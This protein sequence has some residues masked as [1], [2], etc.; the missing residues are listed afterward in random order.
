MRPLAVAALL[1]LAACATQKS[2][3]KTEP[4]VEKQKISNITYFDL[5]SCAAPA[6]ALPE[7]INKEEVFGAA[8]FARPAVLECFV[9]PKNRGPA[10]ESTASV[11]ITVDDSGAH[12]EVGGTNLT[13][14]GTKCIEGAMAKLP[15]KP[16]EKGAAAVST[17]VPFVHGGIAPAVKLGINSGSNVA[18][19]LRLAEAQWCDCWAQVKPPPPSLTVTV[20]LAPGKPGEFTFGP[21][22]GD[23]AALAQCLTQKLQALKLDAAGTELTLTYPVLLIDTLAEGESPD[24]RPELQFIQLD[25]I[26][27]ARAAE[28]ALK[29]GARG[30]AVSTYDALV[31]KYNKVKSSKAAAKEIPGLVKELKDR[32]AAMVKAD[33]AWI[34]ALTAQLTLEKHTEQVA[35]GL[36]AK[37]PMWADAEAAAQKTAE[38]TQAEVTKADGVKKADVGVCPKE[39]Y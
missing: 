21:A 19:Q 16:L 14:D 38:A 6:P 9:D 7:H 35:A 20:K 30:N 36:K 31:Q 33:Q 39:H 25:A 26:R 23:A 28:V 4:V 24:A 18:G 34:D 2:A 8:L 3:G 22:T 11:K 13:P 17:E 10:A 27:S 1:T 29:V 32:C 15:F 5:A 12:Y 37:D